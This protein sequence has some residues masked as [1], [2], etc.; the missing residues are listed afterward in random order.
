MQPTGKLEMAMTD[1]ARRFQNLEYFFA[2]EHGQ[3][4]A[5]GY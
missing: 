3:F 2:L 4:A 5:V 1:G